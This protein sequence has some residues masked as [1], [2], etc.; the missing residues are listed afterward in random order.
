[1]AS[2]YKNVNCPSCGAPV[3]EID[4]FAAMAVCE[5]CGS[6]FHF[7]EDAIKAMGKMAIMV[8]YPTPLYTGARG[9]FN[10]K[11]FTVVGRLRYRFERGFWDEWFLRADSG[12]E[13][14]LAE[15][16]GDF[17]F[18]EEL[19]DTTSVPP[20]E[21]LKPGSR[22][23]IAG[24]S[25]TVDEMDEA[26]LEGVEGALPYVVSM[27]RHFPYVNASQG[28]INVTIEYTSQGPLVYK[29]SWVDQGDIVLDE[30]KEDEE[31]DEWFD[32]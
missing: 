10:G 23:N 25:V 27:D 8:E 20:R 18:Q 17:Y 16:S 14:W 26:Q 3:E 13:I 2:S 31:V 9:S 6:G 4:R 1:M 21:S 22:L 28:D 29:G 32:A 7:D 15:E 12:E 11:R 30:P 5:Y 24:S 19:S